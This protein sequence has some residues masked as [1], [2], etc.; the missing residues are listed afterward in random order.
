MASFSFAFPAGERWD[1][2]TQASASYD[3]GKVSV[4]P[5]QTIKAKGFL[6]DYLPSQ[7]AEGT[8]LDASKM[9]TTAIA[10]ATQPAPAQ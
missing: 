3:G 1:R 9:P 2:P 8:Y 10:P 6:K 4:E 7:T 5:G